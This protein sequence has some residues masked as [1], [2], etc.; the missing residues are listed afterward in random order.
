MNIFR[1]SVG[2]DP[3]FDENGQVLRE[4]RFMNRKEIIAI[5][6][7]YPEY[8]RDEFWGMH[9]RGYIDCN[10]FKTR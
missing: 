4:V 1:Q 10:V 7:L 8:L 3:E 9:E 5:E 2:E 6:N